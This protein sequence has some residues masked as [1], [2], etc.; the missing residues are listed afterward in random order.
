MIS[1]IVSATN[2]IY[3]HSAIIIQYVNPWKLR[4]VDLQE[5]KR[6]GTKIVDSLL[7]MEPI[8]IYL[9]YLTSL[10]KFTLQDLNSNFL[11]LA[12]TRFSEFKG[13]FE[14]YPVDKLCYTHSL[15]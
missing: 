2:W 14:V 4:S 6:L 8:K 15:E 7:I 9:S 11:S 3:L 1:Y 5:N 12:I 13:I 10:K